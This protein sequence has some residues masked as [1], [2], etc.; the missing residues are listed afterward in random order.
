MNRLPNNCCA[1][2]LA[3]L[4]VFRAGRA[5]AQSE[6]DTLAATSPIGWNS[7][8]SLPATSAKI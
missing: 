5:L 1:Q 4:T 2:L 7:L 6:R 3:L 8:T